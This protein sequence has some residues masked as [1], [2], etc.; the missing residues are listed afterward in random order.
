LA[1]EAILGE[2][3][4]SHKRAK[5][6]IAHLREGGEGFDFLGFHHRYVR[7]RT[8]RSRHLTFLVRWPSRQAV[9]HARNR[10][11]EITARDR[12]LLPVED[13]VQDLNWF[14]R[15]WAGYFRYGNFAQFFDKISLYALNRLAIL[16]AAIFLTEV[17]RLVVDFHR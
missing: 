13:V 5:T 4:L 11:R 15:G 12:L 10:V 3:G 17:V 7:G 8:P 9:R 14:L 1:L 16:V 2:R 6:R